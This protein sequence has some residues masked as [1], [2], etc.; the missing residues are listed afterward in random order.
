MSNKMKI[1]TYDR[2][3]AGFRHLGFSDVADLSG[4]THLLGFAGVMVPWQI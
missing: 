1:K 2:S 3:R 4:T